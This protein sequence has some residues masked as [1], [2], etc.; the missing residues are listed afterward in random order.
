V[1][2][3]EPVFA[4]GF[5]KAKLTTETRLINH[6]CEQKRRWLHRED[7]AEK[8]AFVIYHHFYVRTMTRRKTPTFESFAH[9]KLYLAFVRFARHVIYLEAV[10]PLGFVDFLLRIES[11]IDHWTNPEIY[12][13][14]IRELNKNETPLE[15]IERNF[16]LMEQ[17]AISANEDWC[18]FFRLIAPPLAT[19]WII[20]G[21]IS[22]WLLFTAS[23]AP[24]LLKRLNPEQI[25]MVDKAV[26]TEFWQAKMALHQ[27][28]LGTIRAMLIEKR[29]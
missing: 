19:L 25:G 14:Y 24:E 10:H 7:K 4:C 16:M 9:S 13:R 1:T 8:L 29:I 3:S 15:A 17:W 20:S 2:Q 21:R 12:A 5:C 23:S 28:N 6:V 11:P 18:D 26:D 22:P 27:E